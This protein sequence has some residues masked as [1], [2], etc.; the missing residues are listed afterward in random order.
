M[1]TLTKE[2]LANLLSESY[3]RGVIDKTGRPVK[4][5]GSKSFID[6][7]NEAVHAVINGFSGAHDDHG[8]EQYWAFRNEFGELCITDRWDVAKNIPFA[9][10]E[11]RGAKVNK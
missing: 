9:L 2:Q 4:W 10:V 5:M 11:L 7:R 3:S 6:S 8:R 1:I